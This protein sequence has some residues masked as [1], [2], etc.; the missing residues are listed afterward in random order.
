MVATLGVVGPDVTGSRT[1]GIVGC[2]GGT[3][4]TSGRSYRETGGFGCCRRGIDNDRWTGTRSSRNNALAV[5][6]NFKPLC[7]VTRILCAHT[8]LFQYL[9]DILCRYPERS[10]EVVHSLVAGMPLFLCITAVCGTLTGTKYYTEEQC[11]YITRMNRKNFII[12]LFTWVRTRT[13]SSARFY[14]SS[15]NT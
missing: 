12:Y 8:V 1:R 4:G 9:E 13:Y 15:M 2:A 11:L 6:W 14:Q 3:R 10:P 5:A 7:H